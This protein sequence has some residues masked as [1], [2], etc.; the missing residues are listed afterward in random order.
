MRVLVTGG[1]GYIGSILVAELINE[2]YEINILDDLSSGYMDNIHPASNFIKGSILNRRNVRESLAG[3]EAVI[4]LAA[5]SIVSESLKNPKL[6]L[7]VNFEGTKLIAHEAKNKNVKK[8]LY[9]STAS[10]YGSTINKII[11]EN[12]RINPINPYGY[13]KYKSD[14]LLKKV[15]G[16]GSTMCVVFR[17]FNVAVA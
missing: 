3:C 4:H 14:K 9:S 6:Y 12:S 2:G 13:S 15:F 10:V 7:R 8:F 5:K 11:D 16:S 17:F 1:A